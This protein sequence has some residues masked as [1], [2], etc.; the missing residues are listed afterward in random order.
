M[1]D[2]E[3]V[4]NLCVDIEREGRGAFRRVAEKVGENPSTITLAVD[5]V[6]KYVGHPLVETTVK[7]NRVAKL[8]PYGE[9]YVKCCPEVISAWNRL[10]LMIAGAENSK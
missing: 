2:L 3:Y 7:G 6:E 9:V 10:E 1:R 8:T 5:R 4:L